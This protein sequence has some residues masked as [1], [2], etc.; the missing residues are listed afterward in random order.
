MPTR[1]S[2]S[3]PRPP[4]RPAA[5]A[6]EARGATVALAEAAGAA[7]DREAPPAEGGGAA[8]TPARLRRVP[9]QDRGQRRVDRLLEAAAEVI[10]EVGVDGA[11]TNAIA[12]R[13]HTSVGSLY[14]F[15]PNKDAIVHALAARYTAEF[16]QLKDR[17]MALEV[18]DLPLDRMMRGIVEPIAAYCDANPA[19]RH[20]YAA[21]SDAVAGPSPDEARLHAAVVA[22]VESL[23]ARRCPWVPPAQRHVAAVVQVETVHAILFHMQA[24]PREERPALR[25]ELVRMIVCAL[26]PFDR[27]RPTP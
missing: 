1:S 24:R 22:R 18:A 13:A 27:M 4:R 26:E 2:T 3:R 15:F 6:A 12:A 7:D 9:Q 20:V 21:T 16:E 19:Y 5:P 11:T 17:V 23:I 14:Q 10:A 25:E 8:P